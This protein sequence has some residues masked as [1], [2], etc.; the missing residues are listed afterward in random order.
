MDLVAIVRHFCAELNT[1]DVYPPTHKM[2]G[3]Q[4]QLLK[5]LFLFLIKGCRMGRSD[6]A[7]L[8]Y[9]SLLIN[10]RFCFF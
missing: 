10:T 8:W 6:K 7:S 2:C 1:I 5:V 3:F 9:V 4:L